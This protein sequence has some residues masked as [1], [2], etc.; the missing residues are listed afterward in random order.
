MSERK[1]RNWLVFLL[2]LVVTVGATVS[3]CR[4]DAGWRRPTPSPTVTVTETR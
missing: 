3:Y 4:G 2:V 1:P